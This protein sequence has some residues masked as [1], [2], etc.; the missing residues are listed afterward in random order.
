[1]TQAASDADAPTSLGAQF[2]SLDRVYWIANWMEMFER[3]AY[4]GLRTVVPIYMVLSV[5]QGGPEFDH[6]QK[7]QIFAVWAAIQS[8]VPIFTGGYADRYGYKLTVAA[9]IA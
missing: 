4:Y 2:G 9:A 8:F 5:Q 1:M 3:L 7:G 6:V